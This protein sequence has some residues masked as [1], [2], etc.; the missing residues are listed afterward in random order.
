MLNRAGNRGAIRHWSKGTPQ[1]SNL[2]HKSGM[3]ALHFDG[4]DD[5]RATSVDAQS[6]ELVPRVDRVQ[7]VI[8]SNGN[9]SYWRGQCR[10][11]DGDGDRL[12][13]RVEGGGGATRVAGLAAE[14]AAALRGSTIV[15]AVAA[16]EDVAG[17]VGGALPSCLPSPRRP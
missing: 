3:H 8:G 1:I 13:L 15:S 11:L 7:G 6:I 2:S 16:T 14:V 10:N 17:T 9:D 5:E 4:V 12:S